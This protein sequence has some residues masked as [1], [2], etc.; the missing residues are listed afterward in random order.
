MTNF[1]AILNRLNGECEI[2]G[3]IERKWRGVRMEIRRVGI[4]LKEVN[5]E[6]GIKTRKIRRKIKKIS[7]GADFLLDWIGTKSTMIQFDRWVSRLD[8]AAE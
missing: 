7:R 5:I 1:A 2:F 8:I 4:W 3:K 6:D